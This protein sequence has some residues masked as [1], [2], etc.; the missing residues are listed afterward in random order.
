MTK[1]I[2]EKIIKSD[3]EKVFEMISNFEN[4]KELF[5]KYYPSIIT[6]SV[7]DESSLVA[8]HLKLDD[9]EFVIMAK[10]FNDP[11]HRHEMRVVGGDIKGSYIVEELTSNQSETKIVVNA[12]INA[13]KRFGIALKNTNYK[14]ALEEMYDNIVRVIEKN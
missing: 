1:I 8:E 2:F 4:F 6:K 7:R 9:K 10:H 5:P 11:P 14:K 3:I 12:E 13:K